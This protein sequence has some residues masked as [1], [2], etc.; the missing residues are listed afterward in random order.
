MATAYQ[1]LVKIR[2]PYYVSMASPGNWVWNAADSTY[3]I[4]VDSLPAM[5]TQHFN[6]V[7]SVHCVDGIMGQWQCTKAWIVPGNNTCLPT[8]PSWDQ[9]IIRMHGFCQSSGASGLI[10]KNTGPGNMSSPRPYRLYAG[11][12]II[13][14]GNYQLNSGDS[15]ILTQ[16]QPGNKVEADQ[17]DANPF[18][19][20]VATTLQY[21]TAQNVGTSNGYSHNYS[22]FGDETEDCGQI[23]D[24]FDPNEKTAL[25]EGSG[26]ESY[27]RSGATI[28]YTLHFQ[29]M[30]N[31][32]AFKVLVADS[33]STDL[34]PTSLQITAASH[35]YKLKIRGNEQRP[36]LHFIFDPIA[37][38]DTLTNKEKS[39]GFISFTIKLKPGLPQGRV[40]T[41]TA[42]IYFDQNKAV[43]T[44]TTLHT[45]RD[46]Y[47]ILTSISDYANKNQIL[48]LP[49]PNDGQFSL[50]LGEEVTGTLT[51]TNL[52]GKSIEQWNVNPDF[53]KR[54]I[55]LRKQITPGLYVLKFENQNGV[56]MTSRLVIQ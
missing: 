54:E 11:A 31:D 18:G 3:Q 37:L 44:N 52:L 24:S 6:W 29:N 34:D 43:V 12:S 28:F 45:V 56:V 53:L 4:L 32:T 23:R 47:P 19:K 20:W 2:L 7:D 14:T 26:P 49:N 15:L 36:A 1:T 51:L 38:T 46:N 25:P 10:L 41:N 22:A 5:A 50:N 55:D 21:C 42:S 8:I 40:I 13:Q 48:V 9:S 16:V 27:V 35:P 39:T 30:G 33:L 17:G